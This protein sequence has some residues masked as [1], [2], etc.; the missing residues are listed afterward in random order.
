MAQ[1]LRA[2]GWQSVAPEEAACIVV[3]SCGFIEPAKQE[4]I[5]VTLSL[6]ETYPDAKIVMAGCLSQR[7]AAELAA[8]MP[9][10]A[11]L[12]GNR[13]PGRIAEFL[14]R[15]LTPETSAPGPIVSLPE[16]PLL[17][18][19]RE[20]LLGFPG[21]AYVKVSEGCDNRCSFCAIPLIRGRMR[22][23]PL[24]ALLEEI[25]QLLTA[26]VKE[27]NLVAQDLASY[28]RDFPNTTDSDLPGVR[29]LRELSLRPGTFWIRL[30]YVYPD[31]FPDA[32]LSI[33]AE[34]PRIV[35]YFDLPLQHAA[36]PV[37]RRMGRPGTAESYLSLIRGIRD[38]VPDV[39][40]RSTLLV[41]FFGETEQAFEEL[42]AF[43]DDA[44]IDWL[45]VFPYSPEDGTP[46][47]RGDPDL[48][49][50]PELAEARAKIVQERQQPITFESVDR[51]V[52]REL[53][54]LVEELVPDEPLALGRCYAQAPEVDGA[55]VIHTA[56]DSPVTP[57]E[58]LRCRIHRRNGLDVEAVPL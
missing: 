8:E 22:S 13:A 16:E 20:Q 37:L 30:L 44:R 33:M 42:L 29:L 46:A 38:R 24:G 52:G 27:I 12:Y 51:L 47:L 1:S 49:V 6:V 3:N 19:P 4:S 53:D 26:G 58:F 15:V 54:V 32:F 56:G 5:D 18:S 50:S 35:P 36:T 31:R 11:G 40:L 2:A 23:K 28:G 14:A 43:Q 41:G 10:L 57:G 55:V 7:Y 21:S 48:D 17:S 25:D 34:D 9:E 45:G 39:F